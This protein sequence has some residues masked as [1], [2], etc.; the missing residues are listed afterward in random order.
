MEQ[1]QELPLKHKPLGIKAYGSIPHIHGSRLGPGDHTCSQG[2]SDICRYGKE[3]KTVWIQTKLDGSCCAVAM[4]DEGQLLALSR[5]GYLARTSNYELHHIFADWVE[6]YE[7]RFRAVLT[8]GSRLVGEWLGQAHGTK[9]NLGGDDPFIPFDFMIGHNR[10]PIGLFYDSIGHCFELPDLAKGARE[11]EQAME[12]L[13]HFGAE[14]PEGIIYRVESK[15]LG[16]THT[17]FIAKWVQPNK[18]DGKYL[19][20]EPIWNWTPEDEVGM[21]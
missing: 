1:K 17:D 3:S 11:P 8:P 4:T 18:V 7:A 19:K 6:R 2:Q 13:Y 9:Y 14:E 15:K 12:D 21:A 10:M 16:L 5:A 20:G